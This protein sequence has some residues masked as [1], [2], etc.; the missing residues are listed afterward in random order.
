MKQFEDQARETLRGVRESVDA[1]HVQAF[2]TFLRREKRKRRGL[3][4]LLMGGFVLIVA[5]MAAIWWH[6]EHS[7]VATDATAQKT[8]EVSRISPGDPASADRTLHQTA[9]PDDLIALSADTR[10]DTPTGNVKNTEEASPSQPIAASL[11]AIHKSRLATSVPANTAPSAK[12]QSE[13][14]SVQS[15]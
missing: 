2:A 11:T 12:E 10:E 14:A 9:M 1:A 3:F 15:L 5:A 8:N 4:V 13:Q 6:R 7:Q